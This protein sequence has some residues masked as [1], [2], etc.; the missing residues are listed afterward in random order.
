MTLKI[1]RLSRSELEGLVDKLS[2]LVTETNQRTLELAEFVDSASNFDITIFRDWMDQIKQ[3]DEDRRRWQFRAT[4]LNEQVNLLEKL[5]GFLLDDV[6]KTIDDNIDDCLKIIKNLNLEN[7]EITLL[8]ETLSSC[9]ERLVEVKEQL[10]LNPDE[11]QG[12]SNSA[13]SE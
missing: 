7:T 6:F 11:K 3:S 1:S 9:H 8:E 12:E 2:M 5:K 13:E 4:V 10:A